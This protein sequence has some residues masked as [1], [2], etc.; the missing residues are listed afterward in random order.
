MLD[1]FEITEQF[2][3]YRFIGKSIYTRAWQDTS[4]AIERASW[5]LCDWVF[6]ALDNLKEYAT[7]QKHNHAL[8]SWDK[9]CD[10]SQLMGYTIGRFMK[11]DT[12]VP[13][14]MDYI[15]IEGTTVACGW[16][17]GDFEDVN[18]LDQVYNIFYEKSGPPTF[19]ALKQAGYD[20]KCFPWTAQV[21]PVGY[22]KNPKPCD[23]GKYYVGN[24]VP[25]VKK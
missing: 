10:K 5:H 8:F 24:F 14:G 6:E 18:R 3:P 1:K 17:S 22:P 2:G 19:D 20:E 7:D 16:A 15:D 13:E 4:I 9:F 23:D 21:F 25:C 12:P 11:P